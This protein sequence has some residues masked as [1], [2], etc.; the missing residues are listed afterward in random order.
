[1]LGTIKLIKVIK[2]KVGWNDDSEMIYQ[3]FWCFTNSPKFI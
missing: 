3:F 2:N 1:M